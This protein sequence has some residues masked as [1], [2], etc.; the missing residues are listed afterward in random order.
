LPIPFFVLVEPAVPSRTLYNRAAAL[1]GQ[2][3]R[4][5]DLLGIARVIAG[6]PTRAEDTRQWVARRNRQSSGSA[7]PEVS[8]NP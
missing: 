8:K 1:L 2:M 6:A 7:I 4:N 5:S 3:L